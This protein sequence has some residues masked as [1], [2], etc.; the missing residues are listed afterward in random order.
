MPKPNDQSSPRRLWVG[1]L[2]VVLAV[3]FPL[4]ATPTRADLSSL[5]N[6]ISQTPIA[7]KVILA[8]LHT[9]LPLRLDANT[10]YQTVPNPPGNPFAVAR[11]RRVGF[12]TQNLTHSLAPGDYVVP[13]TAYCSQYSVHRPGQG[14]AYELA[15]MQGKDAQAI[16]ALLWR[17][18]L[19]G[20][21]RGRLQEVSW[22]IQSG[23]MPSKMSKEDQQVV[24]SVIPDYKKSLQ[25][26]YVQDIETSF[27]GLSAASRG[28]FPTLESLLKQSGTP[29]Q[30]VLDAL[31]QR[32]HFMQQGVSDQHRREVLFAGQGK[33]DLAQPDANGPWTVLRPGVAYARFH[34]VG[35]NMQSNNY[36]E[37]RVLS[38]VQQRQTVSL[39][40]SQPS[41]D[42]SLAAL[43]GADSVLS[44]SSSRGT[45]SFASYHVTPAPVSVASPT[46]APRGLLRRIG[47]QINT[48][49]GQLGK[50]LG[51]LSSSASSSSEEPDPGTPMIGY[52][53]GGGGAQALAPVPVVSPAPSPQASPQAECANA[54]PA[55]SL[56]VAPISESKWQDLTL[57]DVHNIACISLGLSNAGSPSSGASGEIPT[58]GHLYVQMWAGSKHPL[59]GKYAIQAASNKEG[60]LSYV[61]YTENPLAEN[62]PQVFLKGNIMEIHNLAARLISARDYFQDNADTRFT[63]GWDYK[64]VAIGFNSN[65][66]AAGLLL[67]VGVGQD[68]VNRMVGILE[69][70]PPYRRAYSY[71]EG[72]DIVDTFKNPAE[73]R[74][75]S[76]RVPNE[77]SV[78]PRSSVSSPI[79][80]FLRGCILSFPI[81]TPAVPFPN[82]CTNALRVPYKYDGEIIHVNRLWVIQQVSLFVPEMWIA[83]PLSDLEK[84]AEGWMPSP[85]M[86]DPYFKQGDILHVQ[87]KGSIVKVWVTRTSK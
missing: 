84:N 43:M 66:Y 55:T 61:H 85:Y 31:Q 39:R 12:T 56:P 21:D 78:A 1:A 82:T 41:F 59:P 11:A 20:V 67:A 34:I 76:S 5:L 80:A 60:A 64:G 48:G 18:S 23:V 3:V 9:E 58:A 27:N 42:T 30:L 36:M 45:A 37:L 54:M 14:T 81:G 26:D 13:M 25:S 40:A 68:E 77:I 69:S 38:Q 44:L 57:L 50:S 65:T 49:A 51:G 16:G 19:R 35:G 71:E 75:G 2:V 33:P 15:P 6:S 83:Y 10:A 29:G 22:A 52:S 63:D 86:P 32:T 87:G 53:I 7:Q 24:D 46:P 72:M 73:I 4:L 28:R 8:K 74:S 47:Q 17:G 79:H 62:Q 70:N